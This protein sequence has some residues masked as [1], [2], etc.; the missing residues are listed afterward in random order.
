MERSNDA[1]S[2]YYYCTR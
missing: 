1:L 2:I